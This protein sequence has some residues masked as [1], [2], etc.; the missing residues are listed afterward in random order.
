MQVAFDWEGELIADTW[1]IHIMGPAYYFASRSALAP[2]P[3]SDDHPSGR[4]RLELLC[5]QLEKRGYF[6]LE[7]EAGECLQAEG[8]QQTQGTDTMAEGDAVY[9]AAEKLLSGAKPDIFGIVEKQPKAFTPERFAG[10]A[11][12]LT[13]RLCNLV[14][15]DETDGVPAEM[16][17]VLNAGWLVRLRRWEYF[18][19]AVG[20]KDDPARRFD[21]LS[22]LNNLLLKA[23]EYSAVRTHWQAAS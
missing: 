17:D 12:S 18:C 20:A 3:P 11:W 9:L 16:P 5:E 2:T 13:E 1:G 22:K 10:V 15:P 8:L 14:P 19:C 6:G 23:L 4:F 7:G 21:A